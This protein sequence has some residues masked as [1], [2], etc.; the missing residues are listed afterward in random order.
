MQNKLLISIAFLLMSFTAMS[1]DS[2]TVY[3]FTGNQVR[4]M[5]RVLLEYENVLAQ[6]KTLWEMTQWSDSVKSTQMNVIVQLDDLLVI[7]E[8]QIGNLKHQI[9]LEQDKFGLA[10]EQIRN[11]RGWKRFWMVATGLTAGFL[12]LSLL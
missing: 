10:G 6:N 9:V 12:A 2:L 8:D 4:T 11:E 7:K 3:P 5:S 1:Q